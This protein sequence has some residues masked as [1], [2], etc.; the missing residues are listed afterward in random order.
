[1]EAGGNALGNAL[2]NALNNALVTHWKTGIALASAQHG[3]HI[4]TCALTRSLGQGHVAS[5][6]KLELN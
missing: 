2:S 5:S 6:I 4:A 3:K 1:M